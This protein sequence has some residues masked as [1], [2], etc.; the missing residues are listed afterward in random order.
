MGTRLLDRNGIEC[1]VGTQATIEKVVAPSTVAKHDSSKATLL[2]ISRFLD[3]LLGC[4]ISRVCLG[5]DSVHGARRKKILGHLDQRL[6]ADTLASQ[7][8][9]HDYTN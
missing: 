1:C 3:D 6:S 7:V 5:L 8:G 9:C 4:N 2:L